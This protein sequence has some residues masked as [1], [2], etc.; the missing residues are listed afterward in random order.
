MK[1][2][3]ASKNFTVT[4][5]ALAVALALTL[6]SRAQGAPGTDPSE[7]GE[8]WQAPQDLRL[9]K[10]EKTYVETTPEPRQ[11]EADKVFQQGNR[12]FEK[13]QLDDAIRLY[14]KAY[15]LWPH[16]IILFN[17]AINLGFLS[18]PLGA[19]EMFRKVLEYRPGPISP[20]RY[21]EA[22][23]N[24]KRLMKQLSTLRVRCSEPGA[25]VF[26]D[27]KALGVAPL[28]M[29]LTLDPGRHLVAARLKEKVPYSAELDLKPGHHGELTVFLQAFVDVV[30][31]RV[32]PRYHWWVPTLA[33]VVAAIA[34][35]AGAG[36][37]SDGREA[38]SDL[39]SDQ[40]KAL[41]VPENNNYPIQYDT[42]EES[43]AKSYQVAGQVLVGVAT[44]A[45]V[46]AVVLWAIRKKRES[47]TIDMK[48]TAK[49]GGV[50]LSF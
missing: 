42:R 27:G 13:R 1:D 7:S 22:A 17:M 46:T 5:L 37:W 33:S 50:S 20:E 19:A 39:R 44:A 29:I 31:T 47:F 9:P 48:A 36:L 38:I 34:V 3:I 49:G 43:R 8:F 30:K 32:V 41:S 40:L 4:G 2:R 15:E 10:Q 16:P 45:A 35:G 28:D 14:R 18:N 12:R 21:I 23:Q 11:L 25:E 24:Y 26:V 6:S